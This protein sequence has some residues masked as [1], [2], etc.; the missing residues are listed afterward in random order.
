MARTPK[1]TASASQARTAKAPKVAKAVKPPIGDQGAAAV[2]QAI[3]AASDVALVMDAQGKILE[4]LSPRGGL[5]GCDPQAWRGRTW[6][7]T[8]TIESREK[9]GALLEDAL[10]GRP[11]SAKWRQVNHPVADGEDLPVLY[12]TTLMSAAG[13]APT[14]RIIAFGRDLTATVTLQRRLVEAQQAM[15]Q[16]YWRFREAETRYRHLFE[17]STEAVLIVDGLSL[18]ISEANPAARSLCGGSRGKL[19]GTVLPTLFATE[20]AEA[21][22][23]LLASARSVGGPQALRARLSAD[24]TEVLVSASVFRQQDSAFLLVRL[25]PAQSA[26]VSTPSGTRAARAA[27]QSAGTAPAGLLSAYMQHSPDGLVFCD[28]D[29][30]IVAANR[31]FLSL[32]QLGT[33]EQVRS[34]PLERWVG[35]TGVESSVLITHLRQRGSMGLFVTSV[36]GEYGATCEVEISGTTLTTEGTTV[37]AFSLRDIE[38]RLKSAG[39]P[40][41]TAMPRSTSE[42]TELVGRSPLKDIVAETTDLIEQLCIETALQMTQD[43]RASAALL[44]GLSRQSLYVK[45]RRYGVGNLGG[46]DT[47]DD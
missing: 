5:G 36:R 8:V 32:V 37:L 3:E 30:R 21:L 31:A 27:A 20:H 16:D 10:S 2:W 1:T 39:E 38:R 14:Q 22:Q 41:N 19:A 44:L 34:Q 28:Q 9:V 46:D 4:V 26:A 17:T 11:P 43:N 12:A 13:A 25:I 6:S 24:K 33:E 7:Q 35:R 47:A 18:K 29:G 40:G 23:N 15:E 45:M 42:L